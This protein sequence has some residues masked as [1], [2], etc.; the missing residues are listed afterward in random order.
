[1][2]ICMTVLEYHWGPRLVAL[3][4]PIFQSTKHSRMPN[5][6]LRR[7]QGQN[8]VNLLRIT[9]ICAIAPREMCKPKI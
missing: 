5:N 7:A 9:P 3:K 2:R 1:M 4:D 8:V 6:L